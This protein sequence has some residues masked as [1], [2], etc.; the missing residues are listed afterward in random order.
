TLGRVCMTLSY[1][2]SITF[3]LI[4]RPNRFSPEK[5][6]VIID[7]T[8]V[9]KNSDQF[10]LVSEWFFS[11]DRESV[12]RGLKL[13]GLDQQARGAQVIPGIVC[14]EIRSPLI[15]PEAI[16]GVIIYHSMLQEVLQWEAEARQKGETSWAIYV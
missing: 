13:L 11:S 15:P 1:D 4:G 8:Y 7:P 9:K 12:S 6:I 2:S 14:Y 5:F 16:S 3:P 10:E